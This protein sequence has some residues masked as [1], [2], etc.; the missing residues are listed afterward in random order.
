MKKIGVMLLLVVGVLAGCGGSSEVETEE[1]AAE[2]LESYLLETYGGRDD[3]SEV[4]VM[5]QDGVVSEADYMLLPNASEEATD[6]IGYV[7]YPIVMRTYLS[8]DSDPFNSASPTTEESFEQLDMLYSHSAVPESY[9]SPLYT[10]EGE[11]QFAEELLT[12][13]PHQQTGEVYVRQSDDRGPLIISYVREGSL[14]HELK[15]AQKAQFDASDEDY[16]FTEE[17]VLLNDVPYLRY[18]REQ[19]SQVQA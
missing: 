6:T 15:R 18:T 1:I 2:S 14:Q 5:E 7:S 10:E 13:H 4:M 16:V 19:A 17:K 9:D 3:V 12:A 8:Q 11:F